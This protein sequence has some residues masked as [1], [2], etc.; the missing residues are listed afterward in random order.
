ML[1]AGLLI[2]VGGIG[3]L[4]GVLR[5]E[6]RPNA[7]PALASPIDAAEPAWLRDLRADLRGLGEAIRNMPTA[8]VDRAPA[9]APRDDSAALLA[10]LSRLESHIA[11]LES[12][13]ATSHPTPAIAD[14]RLLERLDRESQK[15]G[16]GPESGFAGEYDAWTSAIG[17]E[18]TRAH[19]LWTLDQV[20]SVYGNPASVSQS[21]GQIFE[22]AYPF[23]RLDDTSSLGVLFRFASERVIE[24]RIDTL[25]TSSR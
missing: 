18:L 16:W 17:A 11:Q 8:A 22:L 24:A 15:F 19:Q 3:F 23:R 1:G 21:K 9:V 20:L 6:S 14:T 12:R 4:L 2:A 10:F 5:A 7:A 25:D 13:A